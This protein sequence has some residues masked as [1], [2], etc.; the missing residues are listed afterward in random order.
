MNL[1]QKNVFRAVAVWFSAALLLACDP[2]AA[3][4]DAS[5]P[6]PDGGVDASTAL[7]AAADAST[8][9]AS[10]PDASAPDAS[11]PDASLPTGIQLL[12]DHNFL[13]GFNTYPITPSTTPIG[14]LIP[15]TSTGSPVWQL[16]EW[17]TQLLLA[18]VPPNITPDGAQWANA[19]KGVV[20]DDGFLELA[21]N[22]DAEWGGVYRQSGQQWPHL[23][24]AQLIYNS[25]APSSNTPIHSY[26][27]VTM[28]LQIERV[29]TD[30]IQESGYDPSL[31]ACQF[32]MFLTLQNRNQ[33]HADYGNYIWFGL[34]FY[35]DRYVT[36][37]ESVDVDIG[38]G[39]YMFR[40]ASANFMPASLHNQ[41]VVNISVNLLPYMRAAVED[42]IALGIFLS[43]NLDD[44][45]IGGM[46]LGFEVPGRSIA[47]FRVRDFNILATL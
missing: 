9:D 8:P 4:D 31:H 36:L 26:A 37:N 45:F 19:F 24:I 7:D 16:A 43:P 44:Y 3:D 11:A 12:H 15:P 41:S 25:A 27:S 5:A 40:M 20:V 39:H 2:A 21:I 34:P 18:N 1:L 46:N 47:T 33:S 23:L 35:D 30:H 17:H 22:A 32:L 6:R 38:T 42:A 10:A 14:T 13:D 28:S 29:Y